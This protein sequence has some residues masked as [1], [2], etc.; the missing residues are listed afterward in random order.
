[1]R[2]LIVSQYFWPETFIIND[3]VRGLKER[4]HELTILTGM[5]NYPAG[6]FFSGYGFF[7]PAREE[8]HGCRVVRVP[9]VPRGGGR[10]WRLA[11]NYLSFVLSATLLGSIRCRGEHDLIFVYEPSPVT[12]CL[13][14]IV[15]K[16]LKGIPLMFWVQDLWPE[17][18][19][20]TGA[21]HSGRILRKV[22]KMVRFIYR[23]CDRILV[24]SEGFIPRVRAVG[25]GPERVRYFPN[26]AEPLY[27]P[28]ELE[29]DAPERD[30]IPEGFC[31]MFAGNLGAAQ[32]LETMVSAADCLRDYADIHWVILGDGR[33]MNWLRDEIRKRKL[34]ERMHLLG[35]KPA[36]KMPRYFALA[37]AL[38]VTLR[39]NPV[40]AL[41]IPSKIQSYLACSRPIL[42]ALDGEGAHVVESSGGGFA[43]GAEDG[44]A[45][46]EAVL[47]V[48]GM[49]EAERTEMGIRGR[50]Y[51]EQHFERERLLTQLEEWMQEVT[52]EGS[53]VS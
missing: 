53:C 33:R 2:I 29:K 50:L 31:L 46:A 22:E 43:V 51:F 49:S 36:E 16:R 34:G 11:L 41:T 48:Y 8:Y 40:F 4:G 12:V 42:A 18:L 38:L 47:R 5:P 23:N 10:G 19:V 44:K 9:L 21:V 52:K 26:W 37:D 30:E 39:S 45:L 35:R 24:Q 7:S 15:L 27:Q 17:S 14:A 25:A 32:S 13:P 28:V 3:L 6:R 1:M 20:A